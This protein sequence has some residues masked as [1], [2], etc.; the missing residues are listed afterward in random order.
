MLKDSITTT[1]I[2]SKQK[3]RKTNQLRRKEYCKRQNYCKQ[4]PCLN[5]YLKD[6]KLNF[7]SNPKTRLIKPAMNEIG[8][9]SKSILDKINNKLRSTTSL[10]QWKFTSE[11]INWLNKIEERSKHTFIV[12]DIKDFYPSISKHF[13]QKTLNLAKTKV[14][15]TQERGK[16]IYHS[17]KFVLF[18]DQETSGRAV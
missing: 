14:S 7:T 10:N 15:I 2:K 6:D 3:H 13:L 17:R 8:R 9:L 16:I 12:F 18:K 4:N 11:V 1:Y 5:G